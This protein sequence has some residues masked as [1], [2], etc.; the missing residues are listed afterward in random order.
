M[1]TNLPPCAQ[2]HAPR[3]GVALLGVIWVIAIIALACVTALRVI[4]FDT[5]IAG[6]KIHGSRALQIAEMGVALGCHPQVKRSDPILRQMNSSTGE[7][8]EVRLASEGGRFNINYILQ[9][10]DR[11][12]LRDIFI[13]WGL[14][15]DAAQAV[16]DAMADWVDEDNNTSLNGAEAKDYEKLG[17]FNQPFNRPFYDVNEMRLVLGMDLVEAMNPNWRQWFTVWSS[18]PLDVNDATTEMIALASESRP[19]QAEIIP[20]T[21][22]GMDGARDTIDDAPFQDA[23]AALDLLGIDV[24]GRPDLAARF[25]ADDST[26]RIE[27]TGYS[28]GAKRKIKIILRNR[29]GRPVLLERTEEIIP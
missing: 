19:E 9:N 14:E 1:K 18:G 27:S 22:R 28:G 16:A 20:E 26:M 29:T 4:S 10:D 15:L 21:V 23:A 3:R 11:A 17:R 5:E 2:C 6:A 13:Y 8:F 25:T 7:G 12:L 24:N